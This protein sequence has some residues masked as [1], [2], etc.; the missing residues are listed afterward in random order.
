MTYTPSIIDQNQSLLVKIPQ[1]GDNEVLVTN[2]L[3][4]SFNF[5]V[6]STSNQKDIVNN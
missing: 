6:S 1:I 3:K 5:D 4:L 2:T